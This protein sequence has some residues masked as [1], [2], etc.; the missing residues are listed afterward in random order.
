VC[1]TRQADVYLQRGRKRD[2]VGEG[3]RLK[4]LYVDILGKIL[5][6]KSK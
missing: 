4:G 6:M 3:G 5:F 2:R 1:D